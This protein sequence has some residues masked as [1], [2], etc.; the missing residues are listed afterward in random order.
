MQRFHVHI[1]VTDLHASVQFY[2]QLDTIEE[3]AELKATAQEAD[4]A[5]L[6]NGQV[7]C[8]CAR[9][10]ST[11]SQTPRASHGCTSTP[12]T[13]SPSFASVPPRLRRRH[14]PAAHPAHSAASPCP[15]PSNQTAADIRYD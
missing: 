15:F 6:D 13:K 11:D 4:M 8:C 2:T 1:H 5:L 12:S 10:T 3:L 9:A 14:R 7:T